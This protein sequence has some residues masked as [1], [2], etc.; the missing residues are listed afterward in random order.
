M[1]LIKSPKI[2]EKITKTKHIKIGW[3]EKNVKYIKASNIVPCQNRIIKLRKI[4]NVFIVVYLIGIRIITLF[5]IIY[6]SLKKNRCIISWE[7]IFVG[8]NKFEIQLLLD[9]IRLRF[10]I[11]VIIIS[12]ATLLFSKT[13]IMNETYFVR[14]HL[15]VISFVISIKLLIL[16]TNLISLLLGWDMLGVTSFLLVAYYNNSKGF[17]ARILTIISNRVGDRIL[18]LAIGLRCYSTVKRFFIASFIPLNYTY[19]FV[20]LITLASITKRAQIP[21][22]AWLPAAIAA[23]TPVSTLVHSSTLVT[24][25]VYLLIRLSYSI[26]DIIINL[27]LIIGLI[28]TILARITALFEIDIKKIVALSTLSQ[29]GLIISRVGLGLYFVAYFHLLVHAFFKALLFITVGN[30]IHRRSDFQDLR[31]G[32]INTKKI[33]ITNIRI[34]TRNLR[35]IGVPFFSRFYSKDII[36]EI[37]LLIHRNFF[38]LLLFLIS[39]ILTVLY[40]FRFIGMT[41]ISYK[42]DLRIRWIED[43]NLHSNIAILILWPIRIVS[44]S[45]MIQVLLPETYSL[46][47]SLEYKILIIVILLLGGF[48]GMILIKQEFKTSRLLYWSF[49]RMWALPFFSGQAPLKLVNYLK[50]LSYL[51]FTLI[52]TL[53]FN[54]FVESAKFLQNKNDV[55]FSINFKFSL[56]LILIIIL[57]IFI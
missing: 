26:T 45:L 3:E 23:P 41:I 40:S 29:L 54:S 15:L 33:L 38:I 4:I 17:N 21:F 37:S 16:R 22:S 1:E 35:L 25:G 55:L 46:V 24:A 9:L 7:I 18:L 57:L 48:F 11:T 20:A 19:I 56:V 49:G 34:I 6:F 28:T 43:T 12:R 51:D 30:M 14:F 39:I 27:I 50:N 42:K 2:A 5:L 13:Y 44:G 31:K 47:L 32:N 10:L 53:S 52:Q 36:I 8:S